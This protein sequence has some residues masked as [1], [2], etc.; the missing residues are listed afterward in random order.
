MSSRRVVQVVEFD[1]PQGGSFIPALD[2]FLAAAAE[3]GWRTEV[4]LPESA[5]GVDWIGQLD[6]H[7]RI[8]FAPECALRS[9]PTRSRWL[10]EQLH[11]D[12]GPTVLHTHF[13]KW[14][15]AALTAS[16]MP[17]VKSTSVF[18]H[19]HSALAR[20]PQLVTRGVLKFG[21]LGRGV[22]GIICPAPNIA[23]GT[24]QWLAPHDRVHFI[25]SAIDADAYPL[26]D[27][28]DRRSAREELGL[29][30]EAKVVLHFGWHTYLKATDTFLEALRVMV[31]RDDSILAIVR[32]HEPISERY[33]AKLDLTG[34]VRFIAPVPRSRTLFAAADVVLSSSREEGMAYTV[35][36]SIATGTPVVATPIPGHTF[37]ADEID[38]CRITRRDPVALADAAM[39][40]IDQ[41]V[42]LRD[43]EAREAHA[44]VAER[45]SIPT[46]SNEI[47]DLYED[48]LDLQVS[49]PR[50]PSPG[51]RPQ[52]RVIQVVQFANPNPGSF[53]PMLAAACRAAIAAG[54]EPEVVIGAGAA[55]HT[56]IDA[57][58]AVG[59][60]VRFAPDTNRD[61]VRRWLREVIDESDGPVILHTHFTD[62]DIAAAGAAL[63][64]SRA[65][66]IWHV[67]SALNHEPAVYVRNVVKFGLISRFVDRL[68]CPAPDLAADLQSRGAPRGLVDFIRNGIDG[69][70]FQ[71]PSPERRSQARA[72]FGLPA[73]GPVAL[74]FAWNWD[75]KGGELFVRTVAT[76]RET[77]SDLSALHITSDPRAGELSVRL[78]L[79]GAIRSIEPVADA[80]ELYA[81][82]DVLLATSERE[83]GTPF[84]VLEALSSGLPVVASDIAAHR[85]IAERAEGI[86]I[87]PRQPDE[88][89]AGLLEAIAVGRPAGGPTL[90]AEFS[91]D[92]WSERIGEVYA[93][94]GVSASS[95]SRM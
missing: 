59:A 57:L 51:R 72:R 73:K 25:P 48:A 3:R 68:I 67:H 32:G 58:R 40:A 14:D 75:L 63:A 12:P 43:R 41:P 54:A 31:D 46:I 83:G 24:M 39:E 50:P 15:I 61:G 94:L 8:R 70:R 62:F 85:F 81:A 49:R 37:I 56:W 65:K 33:A 82:A 27:A 17:G 2:G 16:R 21:V 4:V 76:A 86:V 95:S 35:L 45:L 34:H 30:P 60:R 26:A 1:R 64:S 22:A 7:S 55:G 71:P 23:L 47:V 44:W 28:T 38:A 84:A 90:P 74:G 79:D 80:T 88:F 36:E 53:V 13:T 42:E 89:A 10:A 9:R 20:S 5:A 87:E 78:R 6:A 52:P 93:E 91:L 92:R 18:W 77:L 11:G 29:P 19:V 66:V 69:A